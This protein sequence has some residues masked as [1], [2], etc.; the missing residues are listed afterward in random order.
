MSLFD[1]IM[2][3]VEQNANN[4]VESVAGDGSVTDESGQPSWWWDENTPG[5]GDRPDWLPEKFKSAK[6]AAR[7]FAE[8]EKRLGSAPEQYDWSKGAGWLEPDYEPFQEMAAFA[9]SKHVPQEVLDKMLESVGTYLDEFNI[10]YEEERSQLGD[11][12][13]ERLE[14]LNN[15]AKANFTDET[16]Q[17]LTGNMRTASA[18]KAIEEMRNKM[19]NNNTTIPTGNETTAPTY[20]LEDVQLELKDNLQKYKDDPNY[21]K[22]IQSKLAQVAHQSKYVDKNY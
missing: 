2:G 1:T 6:D 15:W 16:Y 22:Q 3:E 4:N 5:S 9:K 8:L 14:V 7:S 21:R 19:I 10:N 20:S 17:A 12:A 13:K 11:N 18:V